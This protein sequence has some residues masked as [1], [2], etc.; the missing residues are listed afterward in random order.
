[1][2]VPGDCRD[3]TPNLYE[4][5]VATIHQKGEEQRPEERREEEG[6]ETEKV[7]SGVSAEL[8]WELRVSPRICGRSQELS[9]TKSSK[10]KCD[11]IG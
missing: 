6:R 2:G 7:E 8:I 1:M 5:C 3:P 11:K 4:Q 9:R 10:Q